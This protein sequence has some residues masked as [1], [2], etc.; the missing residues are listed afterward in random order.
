LVWC[1]PTCSAS[2]RR[3]AAGNGLDT[4][5]KYLR[6]TKSAAP[7]SC[8]ACAGGA[9]DDKE[10]GSQ[11]RRLERSHIALLFWGA[12]PAAPYAGA[13]PG[14]LRSR[15]RGWIQTA[16]YRGQRS[17]WQVGAAAP[18]P[19]L[20][21]ALGLSCRRLATAGNVALGR[22][23]GSC[24]PGTHVFR[25]ARLVLQTA[26]YRGQRSAWQVGWELPP[27]HSCFPLRSACLADDSLPQATKRPACLAGGL[28]PRA[29][30]ATMTTAPS[31]RTRTWPTF[32]YIVFKT[33]VQAPS[34]ASVL[35]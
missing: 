27:R 18:T 2:K 21:A 4:V 30:N 29:T 8:A 14:A 5:P 13:R 28:L 34:A 22:W 9:R 3:G 17:A 20:S 1:T 6:R 33:Q 7:R 26:R 25:C 32:V 19:P 24:R 35:E 10:L 23:G 11:L 16:R 12:I 31:S 15:T